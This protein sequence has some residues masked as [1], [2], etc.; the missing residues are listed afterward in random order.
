MRDY[1]RLKLKNSSG[2][3]CIFIIRQKAFVFVIGELLLKPFW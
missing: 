3:V 2:T 1:S